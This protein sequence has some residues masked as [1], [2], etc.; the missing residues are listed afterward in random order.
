MLLHTL[1]DIA[2]ALSVEPAVL[3]PTRIE[4]AKERLDAKL[5]AYSS[6]QQEW[7]KTTLAAS[8][9]RAPL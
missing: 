3:L 8:T 9:S 5:K 2:H 4:D 1:V 6:S 7:I